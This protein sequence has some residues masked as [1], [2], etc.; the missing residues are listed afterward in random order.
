LAK[1]GV[2]F[3]EIKY[4]TFISSKSINFEINGTQYKSRQLKDEFLNN[5]VGIRNIDNHFQATKE[6]AVAD[7]LYFNP[8]YHFDNPK[9]IDF[10]QV[11]L[12]QTEVGYVKS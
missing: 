12:I 9:A 7:I 2:I 8:K 6:R 11:K 3:Q 10:D 4:I 5:S 1:E